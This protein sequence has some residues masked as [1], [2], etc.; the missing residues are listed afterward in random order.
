MYEIHAQCNRMFPLHVLLFPHNLHLRLQPYASAKQG[1]A[2]LPCTSS[3]PVHV[4]TSSLHESR[5]PHLQTLSHAVA[6]KGRKSDGDRSGLWG[7]A[8]SNQICNVCQTQTPF[9][10]T[11]TAT[12]SVGRP[13]TY[14]HV[15][16][17]HVLVPLI[18]HMAIFILEWEKNLGQYFLSNPRI[19]GPRPVFLI[20]LDSEYGYSIYA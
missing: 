20:L 2:C 13:C 19:C 15:R 10:Q 16:N 4:A 12:L 11:T 14:T 7:G 1:H 6:P 18:F 9:S 3:L 5:S 8:Q 17:K